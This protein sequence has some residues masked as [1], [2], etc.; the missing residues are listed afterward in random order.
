MGATIV[1]GGDPNKLD[2]AG[3][4]YGDIIAA[5]VTGTLE[6]VTVGADGFV[7]T[8]D[9]VAPEGVDWQA[10]GGGGG[11][12]PS[13]TVVT[14][15]AFGQGSTGGVSTNYSRGDHTHG[16]PTAPTAA[17]VGA[18]P[19]GSAAAA[20][21]A[22]I[23]ASDPVGSAATVNTALSA[24]ITSNNAAVALKAP[25]AAPALTG[26][27]TAANLVQSGRH[28]VSPDVLAFATPLNTDASTGNYFRVTL[29]NNF[30]L[31]NPTNA[32]D[33]QKLMW[34]LIQ[35]GAGSHAITLDT[36][37]ALGTDITA[38]TLS[39]A[40]NKRDFL[41]VVYNA[42]ADLFYVIAFVKGY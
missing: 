26:N 30:T 15:T 28:V 2:V 16:T 3:Y 1:V 19:T 27:A 18:D 6:P 25:L 13:N 38:V 35:D 40:I 24:Y 36:K 17:S 33:G 7:L 37:F 32:V 9:S 21:A 22:A 34:E 8:A 41:G 14:E 31:A 11:G 10:G 4:T 23:A 42:T 5:D 39:T 12:T 20:Q 29:T